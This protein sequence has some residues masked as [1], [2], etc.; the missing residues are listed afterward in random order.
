MMNLKNL[1]VIKRSDTGEVRICEDLDSK[2]GNRYTVLVLNDHDIVH[3]VLETYD[4]AKAYIEKPAYVDMF[5]DQGLFFIVFPYVPERS[6]IKFYMAGSLTLR[7]CEEICVNL[8]IACMTSNMPWPLLYLLLVQREIQLSQDH[9]VQFSY[10]LDLT[11]FDPEIGE[12]ACAVECAKLLIELLEAKVSRR[13]NSYFL[14]KK[15]I[16][17]Q[18]YEYFKDLYKDLMIS[19]EPLRKGGLLLR[20]KLWY[21]RNKD[22]L[23]YVLLRVSIVLALFVL[24]TFLTNL[25]FGDVPWLRLFIRS[26]EK[27]GLESLVQ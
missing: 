6:L 3:S 19:R 15:K 26:F 16:D 2:T 23:F 9:R 21:L 22:T 25:I 11:E 7:E 13:A 18:S 17:R 5:S 12:S 1:S 24:I 4:D 8:I 27:I 10:N 20:L 14:L